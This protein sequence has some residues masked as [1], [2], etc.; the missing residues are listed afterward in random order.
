MDTP[1]LRFPWEPNQK[2]KR[3]PNKE[4]SDNHPSLKLRPSKLTFCEGAGGK[5]ESRREASLSC[6]HLLRGA[7][8]L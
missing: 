2:L 7:T 8:T 1:T 4:R 3:I 5:T 6:S